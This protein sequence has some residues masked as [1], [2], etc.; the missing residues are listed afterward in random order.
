[1]RIT[2][3][4]YIENWTASTGMS[5]QVESGIGEITSI[6]SDANAEPSNTGTGFMPLSVGND[7]QN[8]RNFM[9]V[10]EELTG[11]SL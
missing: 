6:C 11:F 4:G 3:S 1:M 9:L 2:K 10:V 7:R 5:P 8:H